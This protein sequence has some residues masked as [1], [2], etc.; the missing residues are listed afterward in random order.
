MGFQVCITAIINVEDA[1]LSCSLIYGVGSCR[2]K[3]DLARELGW[4]P[5]KTRA[6]FEAHFVDNWKAILASKEKQ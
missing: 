2:T 6:D 5:Q 4:K 3:S 1:V